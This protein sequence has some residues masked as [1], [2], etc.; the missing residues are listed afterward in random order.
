LHFAPDTEDTLEFT[1][2]LANTVASATKSGVDELSTPAQL[3]ALLTTHRY[4]G[5]F[6]RDQNELEE[7]RET[8]ALL[9]HIWLLDRDSAVDEVNGML[10]AASA[11]PHL[12]RHDD[13]DWHLHATE[14]D[15]PL[16]ERIRV[17]VALALV[18]VIR[19]D[20]GGRLRACAAPDCEGLLLDLSR[21]GSKQFCSIR[22]GNRMN[23]IA[24]R[25]RSSHDF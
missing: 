7:V 17:E 1:V 14:P 6:D 19:T 15:A 12:V 11:L 21:N 20:E 9:R 8:R 24:Y 4:S 5:R 16:A 3:T 10:R 25:L 23:M 22:C 13:L 18:D 2:A